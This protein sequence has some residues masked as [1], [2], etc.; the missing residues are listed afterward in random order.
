MNHATAHIEATE[1]PT[2]PPIVNHDGR[3]AVELSDSTVVVWLS[4]TPDELREFASRLAETV[5]ETNPALAV[6]P[7]DLP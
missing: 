4:G 7:A 5:R 6:V 3:F 1:F 2:T